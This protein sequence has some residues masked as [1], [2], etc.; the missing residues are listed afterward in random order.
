MFRYRT[1]CAWRDLPAEFGP[2]QTVWKRHRRFSLDGTWDRILTRLLTEADAAGQLDWN[3]SV[4]STI[5]RVLSAVRPRR[6]LLCRRAGAQGARANRRKDRYGCVTNRTTTASAVDVLEPD[7]TRWRR[8]R[9]TR[10]RRSALTYA[11]GGSPRSSPNPPTRSAT[12]VAEVPLVDAPSTSTPAAYAAA[13]S[14]NAP[15]TGSS[16]GAASPPATT[17]T[18]PP[19][20]EPSSSPPSSPGPTNRETRSRSRG[21]VL[22]TVTSDERDTGAVGGAEELLDVPAASA[23]AGRHGCT[24]AAFIP[25]SIPRAGMDAGDVRERAGQA[26]CPQRDPNQMVA[27][28]RRPR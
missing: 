5:S 27:P 8:T 12:A 14:S 26:W 17:S 19:T 1:G 10:P 23:A 28:I 24:V 9:R 21:A 11:A 15:S 4:D 3:V 18:P 16:S 22:A 20:A 25:R 2:W 13:T 6:G 7:R